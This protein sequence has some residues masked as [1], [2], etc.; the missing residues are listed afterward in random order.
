MLVD[1]LVQIE[2][3]CGVAYLALQDITGVELTIIRS[4]SAP[5]GDLRRGSA[6]E[7]KRIQQAWRAKT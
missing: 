6:K 7:Y 3:L 4:I 1:K 5:V 2:R